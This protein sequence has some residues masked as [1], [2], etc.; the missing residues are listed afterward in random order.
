[1]IQLLVVLTLAGMGCL[2]IGVYCVCYCRDRLTPAG[3]LLEI[4]GGA[5]GLIA[6]GWAIGIALIN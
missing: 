1:M 6:F 3:L 2:A 5:V 4:G